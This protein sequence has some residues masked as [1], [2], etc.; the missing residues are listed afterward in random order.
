MLR[1]ALVLLAIAGCAF[2]LP[3]LD[4]GFAPGGGG[5]PD[6]GGYYWYDQVE[7]PDFFTDNWVDISGTGTPLGLTD[8]SHTLAGTLSFDFNFYGTTYN[9]IYVGS[10]GVVYFEDTY[11]GLS[12]THIPGSNSYG[13]DTF[14]APWW[15]DLNP[16][17]GAGAIYY[18]EFAD[19]FVVLFSAVEVYGGGSPVT[20][21]LIGWEAPGGSTNSDIAFLYNSTTSINGCIGIQGDITTGTE[22]EYDPMDCAPGEWYLLTPDDDYFGGSSVVESSWGEIKVME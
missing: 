19:H 21:E 17:L 1:K 8:D 14:M 6:G 16:S 3:V 7:D 11:L 13:V 18:Q 4:A 10:N 5:G 2:A 12:Y 15:R 9:D 20:F 22:L